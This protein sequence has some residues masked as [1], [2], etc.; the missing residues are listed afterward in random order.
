MWDHVLLTITLANCAW[1]AA[2]DPEHNMPRRHLHQHLARLTNLESP[3][4]NEGDVLVQIKPVDDA[5]SAGTTGSEGTSGGAQWLSFA[6]SEPTAIAAGTAMVNLAATGSSGGQSVQNEVEGAQSINEQP[7]SPEP[8]FSGL[9]GDTGGG[10][11]GPVPQDQADRWVKA[12]NDARS[13][14]GAGELQWREDLAWGAK[15]NAEQC[16]AGHTSVLTRLPL[17]IPSGLQRQVVW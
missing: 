12:H 7:S 10:E 15:S 6:A 16:K 13:A 5:D 17:G 11:P 3:P 9:T 8:S 2:H 14:H 4:H 1:A